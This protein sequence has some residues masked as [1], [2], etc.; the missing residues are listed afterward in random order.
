MLKQSIFMG[1]T[2]FKTIYREYKCFNDDLKN[3]Q[4]MIPICFQLVM[5]V[6]Y[7]NKSLSQSII[8][9]FEKKM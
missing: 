9:E 2:I 1:R 8:L 3:K 5:N 6:R 4:L 7:K